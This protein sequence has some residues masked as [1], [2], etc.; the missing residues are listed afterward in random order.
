MIYA[1]YGLSQRLSCVTP[2]GSTRA[3]RACSSAER[4]RLRVYSSM[5]V[6]VVVTIVVLSLVLRRCSGRSVG[7]LLDAHHDSTIGSGTGGR[8]T[9]VG[10]H[11]TCAWAGPAMSMCSIT[12]S[13]CENRAVNLVVEEHR[14]YHRSSKMGLTRRGS[15]GRTALLGYGMQPYGY[16]FRVEG[17]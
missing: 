5:I 10:C 7:S 4:G 6:R 15:D 16:E 9:S 13:S 3:A 8:W 2:F 11:G 12:T 1:G 14:I 17:I